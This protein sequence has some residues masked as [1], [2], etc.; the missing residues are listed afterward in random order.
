MPSL[1][2]AV[3]LLLLA[4]ASHATAAPTAAPKA[5]PAIAAVL[6]QLGY[7]YEVDEDGDYKMVM[8]IGDD[9]R[10]QLVYVRSPV[11]TYGSYRVRE[12]W[13]PAYRSANGAFPGPVANRLLEASYDLKL[14]AWVKHD[15]HAL[16]VVKVDADAGADAL[17][18]AITAA[19]TSADEMEKELAG[20]PDSDDF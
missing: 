18:E 15:G 9:E 4:L 13:S 8:A 6:D 12:I 20:D 3:A 2:P 7:K 5:D 1:R 17:D 14:G 11:E 19:V 10:T 16:M